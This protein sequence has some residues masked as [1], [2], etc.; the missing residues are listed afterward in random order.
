MACPPAV[1]VN[2]AVDQVINTAATDVKVD[3]GTVVN[4]AVDVAATKVEEETKP[5]IIPNTQ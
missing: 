5:L 4:N 2:T 3:V 1:Q